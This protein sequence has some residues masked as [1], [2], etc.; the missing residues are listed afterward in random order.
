M[1]VDVEIY[2]NNII[3]FF[4]QNEKDL[5][6]LIPKEQEEKFY[7]KIREIALKN[8]EEGKEVGLTQKQL[9]NICRELN[10]KKVLTDELPSSF[11]TTK[12]GVICL[13]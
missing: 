8:S 9:I 4:Q 6:N 13:S 1:S 5:L 12:F 3:K 7:E 10:Q 11:M 2:M